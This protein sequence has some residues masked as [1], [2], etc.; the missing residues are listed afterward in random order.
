MNYFPLLVVVGSAF[1]NRKEEQR[2]LKY[3]IAESVPTLIVS[4]RRYGKTSLATQVIDQSKLSSAQFDFLAAVNESDVEKIILRGIGKMLGQIECIPK[5]LLK[6]SNDFFSGLSIKLSLDKVG[7][8]VEFNRQT[9]AASDNLLDILERLEK[10]SEKHKKKIVLLF[11][12]FQRIYQISESHAIESVIREIA[13][14]SKSLSFIF[15][16]SNRNL[17]NQIFNDRNRPFYKLCDRISL[18]RI[19]E[20]DYTPYILHAAKKTNN[21]SIDESALKVIY[22]LTQRH[23]Y[24]MNLLCSRLCQMKKVTSGSVEK[25]WFQYCLEERSNVANEID[26][27]SESQRKLLI[28]LS[29]SG[30]TDAPRSVEFQTF[31][32]M[33]GASITQ[34]LTVLEKKD[35]VY[36]TEEEYFKVLDPLIQSVLADEW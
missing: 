7:I 16:G 12:E 27:L 22:Q 24:Y 35:Y 4:P 25:T 26:L 29:R 10:L 2:K 28:A 32:S 21:L 17:L 3:N 15:S 31:S 11:D 14:K 23:P 36:K 33:P 20:K 8:S 1:C 19:P 34:A 13:Q 30:G 6:L 5:K 18:K 9:K